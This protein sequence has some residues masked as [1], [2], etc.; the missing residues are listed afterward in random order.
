MKDY[1][2]KQGYYP[3]KITPSIRIRGYK[4]DVTGLK[5]KEVQCVEVKT[6]FNEYSVMGAVTQVRV[7][8]FGSTHGFIAF[9]SSHWNKNSARRIKEFG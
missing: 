9:P 2:E 3:V 6:D 8:M 7:Y 5:A 1:L 4:P